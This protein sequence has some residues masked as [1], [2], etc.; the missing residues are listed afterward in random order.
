MEAETQRGL[1]KISV[2][3]VY[4]CGYAICDELKI[5]S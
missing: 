5:P 4:R 3:W 1:I 2:R